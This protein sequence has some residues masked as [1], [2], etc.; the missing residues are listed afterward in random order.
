MVK[1][2]LYYLHYIKHRKWL[3]LVCV[4]YR[5]LT[6]GRVSSL[7]TLHAVYR[8][9]IL[10]ALHFTVFWQPDK[11]GELLFNNLKKFIFEFGTLIRF[12]FRAIVEVGVTIGLFP[13]AFVDDV[14]IVFVLPVTI[15]WGVCEQAAS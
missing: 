3:E 2:Y 1:I 13:K 12:F 4:R 8:K 14:D 5:V 6:G 11:R 7:I 9:K 15:C 10:F